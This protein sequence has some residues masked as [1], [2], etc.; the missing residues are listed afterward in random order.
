[1]AFWYKP[2]E[3]P[4]RIALFYSLGQLAGALS[5]LLAYAISFMDG[6]GGLSGWRWSF[7]LEGLP[8]ILLS[9]VALLS[10]PDYPETTRTLTEQERDFL[11]NHLSSAPSGEDNSWDWKLSKCFLRALHFTHLRCTGSDMVSAGSG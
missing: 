9:V 4:W 2:S 1:M 7:I 6:A 8:A 10:L 5:G 3:M 11:K